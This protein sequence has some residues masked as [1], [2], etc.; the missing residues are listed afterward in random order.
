MLPDG[1]ADPFDAAGAARSGRAP[2][3]DLTFP[4]HISLD[5]PPS[6]CPFRAYLAPQEG[7]LTRP[8]RRMCPGTLARSSAAC[9]SAATSPSTPRPHS[10]SP[11]SRPR[12]RPADEHRRGRLNGAG[13]ACGSG[14]GHREAG[15]QREASRLPGPAWEQRCCHASPGE[16]GSSGRCAHA[17]GWTM[18]IPRMA[19]RCQQTCLASR[20]ACSPRQLPAQ[21]RSVQRAAGK[22]RQGI[23]TVPAPDSYP[24]VT[25]GGRSRPSAR[26]H[27]RSQRHRTE[28]AAG[29][30]RTRPLMLDDMMLRLKRQPGRPTAG[31]GRDA[32]GPRR[33]RTPE[34]DP[35]A[36]RK[37][38]PAGWS[39]FAGIARI[40]SLGVAV[41]PLSYPASQPS[42]RDSGYPAV[43]AVQLPRSPRRRCL[44]CIRP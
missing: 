16:A 23:A 6:R 41:Q 29:L 27:R 19:V 14:T 8:A 2:N 11:P 39:P 4:C 26:G 13:L 18:R 43:G 22:A 5:Y 15:R 34:A 1:R 12:S 37:K 28:S 31:R 9:C 20:P 7:G 36:A 21:M 17:C 40:R 44:R 10:S 24:H 30:T 38:R 42:R 3:R 32:G 33:P 25:C 35:M